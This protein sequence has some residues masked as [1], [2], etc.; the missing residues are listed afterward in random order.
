MSATPCWDMF[1][2]SYSAYLVLHRVA[3]CAM[4]VEWQH[5]FVALMDEMEEIVDTEKFPGSFHVRAKKNGKFVADPWTDYRHA[6]CPM[7][8]KESS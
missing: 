5:K 3:L 7:R 2:L 4:P 1:E 6:K 8:V